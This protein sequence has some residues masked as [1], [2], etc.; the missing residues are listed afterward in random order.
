MPDSY[1]IDSMPDS[2]YIDSMPDSYYIDFLKWQIKLAA[3]QL[4]GWNL[5]KSINKNFTL[6]FRHYL[7]QISWNSLVLQYPT[8][9][10]PV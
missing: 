8:G 2:Y 1:Y 5:K 10:F 9:A 7:S 4:S 3:Y 6:Y